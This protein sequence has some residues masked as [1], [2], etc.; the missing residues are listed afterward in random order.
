MWHGR[1]RGLASCLRALPRPGSLPHL[2]LPAS[3]PPAHPPRHSPP[4]PLPSTLNAHTQHLPRLPLSHLSHLAHLSAPL[5]PTPPRPTRSQS[6]SPLN[7]PHVAS[8]RFCRLCAMLWIEDPL[9]A[10]FVSQPVCGFPCV[11]VNPGRIR[12][13]WMNATARRDDAG[14]GPV[15]R[16]SLCLFSDERINVNTRH[17]PPFLVTA[18]TQLT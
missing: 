15:R 5:S 7:L 13:C 12:S 2:F 4:S 1:S 6:P 10:V 8:S 14:Q 9:T 3:L 11:G 17:P 16:G 18:C